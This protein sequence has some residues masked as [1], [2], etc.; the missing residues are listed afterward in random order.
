MSRRGNCLDNAAMESWFSPRGGV[1][2]DV[3][4]HRP[5]QEQLFGYIEVFYN[6]KRRQS[7]LDYLSPARYEREHDA[8]L[9]LAP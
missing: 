4:V 6:Q 2:R 3:R 9:Q 7:T 1:R 5:R 8:R